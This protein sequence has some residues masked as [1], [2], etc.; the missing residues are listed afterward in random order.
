[1]L[2]EIWA[3]ALTNLFF[4]PGLKARAIDLKV[5]LNILRMVVQ[6]L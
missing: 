5:Y 4:Y 6:V 1:M 2:R 3:K